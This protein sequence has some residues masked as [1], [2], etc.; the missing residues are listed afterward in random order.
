MLVLFL[1]CIITFFGPITRITKKG[2]TFAKAGTAHN[3]LDLS[4]EFPWVY[5]TIPSTKPCPRFQILPRTWIPYLKGFLTSVDQLVPFQLWTLHKC[6]PTFGTHMNPGPMSVE[7][8]PHCW[9]ITKHL[10]ASLVWA[11]YCPVH[12]I[13]HLF[14]DFHF[15]T[16]SRIVKYTTCYHLY[17]NTSH[18]KTCNY[19]EYMQVQT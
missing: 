12:S 3:T 4:L 15:V 11:R 13:T 5:D 14:L 7:V 16:R 19:I 2:P 1:C 9:V 18:F 10:G 6:F 17:S 8:F